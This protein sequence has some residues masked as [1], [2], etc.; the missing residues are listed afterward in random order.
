MKIINFLFKFLIKQKKFS[1]N[2]NYDT[3]KN[4][5]IQLDKS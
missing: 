4:R 1:K 3:Y 5:F 2:R